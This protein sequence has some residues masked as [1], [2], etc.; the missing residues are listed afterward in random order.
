[1]GLFS[2][3]DRRGGPGR[4]RRAEGPNSD[5]ISGP[6]CRSRSSANASDTRTR[7]SR[8]T[9][10]S[11]A[12]RHECRCSRAVRDPDRRS[13]PVDV[14]R[15]HRRETE[16]RGLP[17]A[18]VGPTERPGDAASE[19]SLGSAELFGERVEVIDDDTDMVHPLNRH[20]ADPRACT[21]QLARVCRPLA[22][23]VDRSIGQA[24][25]CVFG[26]TRKAPLHP[27]QNLKRVRPPGSVPNTTVAERGSTRY[28]CHGGGPCDGAFKGAGMPEPVSSGSAGQPLSAQ[29]FAIRATM[30]GSVTR[31]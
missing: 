27:G 7:P 23:G 28:T 6:A 30:P 16:A 31:A 10:T 29:D 17:P 21:S 4:I 3:P 1:M 26:V 9:P 18:K 12:P 14:H 8:C 13:E 5:V 24:I 11:L 15:G 2:T 22:V 25:T 20:V 19:A